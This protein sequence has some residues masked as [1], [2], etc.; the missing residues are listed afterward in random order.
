MTSSASVKGGR[1]KFK[2]LRYCDMTFHERILY[3]NIA[4]WFHR[5]RGE[6]AE[7]VIAIME[8]R[9]QVPAQRIIEHVTSAYATKHNLHLQDGRYCVRAQYKN[10][11]NGTRKDPNCRGIR[12]PLVYED[13]IVY[14]TFKQAFCLIWFVDSPLPVYIQDN[15]DML[16]HNLNEERKLTPNKKDVSG[17]PLPSICPPPRSIYV[18]HSIPRFDHPK[19]SV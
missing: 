6:K 12:I 18:C 15:Y 11:T 14:T 5:N 7:Y 3:N 13:R 19:G 8:K 10:K 16:K 1:K 9:S 17:I 4:D 2:V